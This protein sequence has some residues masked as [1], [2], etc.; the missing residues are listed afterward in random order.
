MRL[1]AP[2]VYQRDG[3]RHQ[4]VAGRFV[5]RAAN[6]VGFEIGAYDHSRELIIDPVL[7]FSTYFGGSGT[8]T[9]PSVAVNGDGNIYV[10]GSTTSPPNT[11]PLGST[12]PTQ[13]GTAAN[14]FVAKINP[15][16]PP[17]V[18]YATFLGGNGGPGADTSIGIGVDN[19]GNAYIVGNT[20]STNFPTAGIPYQSA[21][22]TKTQCAGSPICTSVFVSVLNPAGS[23]TQLLVLSFRQW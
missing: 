12:I 20:S 3:D 1:Q 13:L 19:G 5:L 4:P 7:V 22:E 15:S 18:V 23:D 2:Q 21:P 11:F 17:S 8:E 14:I 6:R 10:V 9:S 16:Q